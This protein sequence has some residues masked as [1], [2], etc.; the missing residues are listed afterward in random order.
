MMEI[1]KIKCLNCLEITSVLGKLMVPYEGKVVSIKCSNP[2][3]GKPMKVQV[4]KITAYHE[5]RLDANPDLP[6]TQIRANQSCLASSAK[7]KIM[8]NEKTEEQTFILKEGLNTIGRLSLVQNESVPDIQILTS[9]KKISRNYHCAILLQRKG[10]YYEAILR[11]NQ[12]TNGTFLRNSNKPLGPDDEVF[13][14][15]HD[16]F[17]IGETKLQ[18]E[19]E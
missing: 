1:I 4:P 19:L 3:C 10:D 2:Q 8:K 13:L 9:D 11:D 18:I 17:L 15:N 14:G 5:P 6:P 7:I 16:I 12:S